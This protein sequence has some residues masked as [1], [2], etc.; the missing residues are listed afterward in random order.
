M[1]VQGDITCLHCGFDGGVWTGERGSALTYSGLRAQDGAVR[2]APDEQIRC[3]RCQGPVLFGN[4]R[5]AVTPQ[6]LRRIQR[7]REQLARYDEE[8]RRRRS[9]A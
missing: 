4:I 3:Q 7:M 5:A 2:G 8:A 1:L 9:A 6:R